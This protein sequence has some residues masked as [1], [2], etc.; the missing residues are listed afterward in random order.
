MMEDAVG[1]RWNLETLITREDLLDKIQ[2]LLRDVAEACAD[3]QQSLVDRILAYERLGARLGQLWT[4]LYCRQARDRRD[5]D[6]AAALKRLDTAMVTLDA[7][8]RSVRHDL[9][10]LEG[11]DFQALMRTRALSDAAA[12]LAEMRAEGERERRGGA[13]GSPL[14]ELEGSLRWARKA[15]TIFADLTFHLDHPTAP[16]GPIPFSRRFDYLWGDDPEIRRAAWRGLEQ[17]YGRHAS[18]LAECLKGLIGHRR[19]RID[20]IG[21]SPIEEAALS[22]RLAMETV[23]HALNAARSLRDVLGRYLEVKRVILGLPAIEMQD[24]SASS[25]IWRT[26]PKNRTQTVADIRKAFHRTAPL[27][28]KGV[29]RLIERRRIDAEGDGERA[30]A[31][32]CAPDPLGSDPWIFMNLDGGFYA[33]AVFAHELGH[34]VHGSLLEGLRPMNRSVPAAMA[35]TAAITAEYLFR[36]G[37]L[38]TPSASRPARIEALMAELDSAVNYA[39]RIPRDIEFEIELYRR[40]QS[41]SWTVE[42][43]TEASRASH[44]HWFD[45]TIGE[46]GDPYAWA[47]NPLLYDSHRSFL[48]LPYLIGFLLGG[49]IA[50]RFE[51][52]AEGFADPY[53][54][55]L[56]AAGSLTT[57]AAAL[58]MGM[59]LRD[60]RFWTAAASRVERRLEQLIY[61]F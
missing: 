33:Q 7:V 8:G 6:A 55:F 38:Q 40:D 36:E 51:A 13:K 16:P 29:G 24:R 32:F 57:E 61:L 52:D 39:L 20:R 43:L 23:D 3:P 37:V 60:E 34:G 14:P 31:G 18:D 17:A 53:T 41:W 5:H 10:R 54:R 1:L 9:A 46:S 50:E 59:D 2:L 25:P 22:N 28:A 48:N 42:E 58:E 12:T 26:E 19:A 11:S 44:R 15:E 30:P 4:Y 45:G 56:R 27:L 47:S 49:A 35:E 21:L